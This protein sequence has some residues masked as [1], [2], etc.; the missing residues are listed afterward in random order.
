M[1]RDRVFRHALPMVKNGQDAE[2]GTATTFRELWHDRAEVRL[3]E[4]PVLPL[5]LVTATNAARNLRRSARRY[6][7]LLNVLP[8]PES[9]APD[10]ARSSLDAPENSIDT[11]GRRGIGRGF[12]P[13][14]RSICGT[15]A[16][17]RRRWMSSAV[18]CGKCVAP[19]ARNC[20][21]ARLTLPTLSP[22]TGG[23]THEVV[24]AGGA[25][26]WST[27]AGSGFTARSGSA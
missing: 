1:Y 17:G 9:T 14:D 5:Q 12:R 10:A 13:A 15:A 6:R 7:R 19:T 3:V 16:R 24:Y 18:K 26:C 11:Q 21:G 20:R 23:H 22:M 8:R 25:S 4:A 2:H 27:V